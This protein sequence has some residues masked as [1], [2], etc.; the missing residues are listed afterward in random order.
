M[1][2]IIEFLCILTAIFISLSVCACAGNDTIGKITDS[3]QEKIYNSLSDEAQEMLEDIGISSI[4]FDDIFNITPQKICN[5]F[6][7][8]VTG[9]VEAP[10]R[11]L[12]R[13]TAIIVLLAV[14]ECF[15]P[16]DE[17]TKTITQIIGILFCTISIANPLSTAIASAI[18]SI[19]VSEKFML[20]LIPVLACVISLAGNPT[21]AISFQSIAFGAAQVIASISG[22]YIAPAVG[23]ILALDI[24]GAVIPTYNLSG[25]TNLSKKTLTAILSTTATIYVAFLGLKGALA[26]AAD[27]VA[28]RGIRLAISSAVPV[29]GGALSE[30]YS[31]IIGSIILARSTLGIFGIAAIALINLPSCLQ[32]VFWIF[33]L[34]VCASVG[35]LF[36]QNTTAKL[37]RSVASALTLLNVVILFNAVLFIISTALILIIKAG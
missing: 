6:K 14:Y 12:V 16:D 18:A 25:I 22:K 19:S 20:T 23:A 11:S 17:R 26:N 8:L 13:L 31:G 28:S 27:T 36:N 1:K 9:Q 10:T 33:A 3:Q 2:K 30:A 32:L 29:V 5:L 4:S 35:E 34:K 24:T 37:L 7:K 21:L 15:A